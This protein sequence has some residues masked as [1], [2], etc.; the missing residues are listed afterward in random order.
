MEFRILGNLE[1]VSNGEVIDLGGNRIRAFAAGILIHACEP[2]TYDKLSSYIWDEP[3]TS[4]SANLRTYA[5]ALRRKLAIAEAG[6]DRWLKTTSGTYQLLFDPGIMDAAV[7]DSLVAESERHFTCGDIARCVAKLDR[8]LQLW[9]GRPMQNVRGSWLLS[10]EIAC[11]EERYLV[12]AERRADLF[13]A[14]RHYADSI[15]Y[16]RSLVSEFPL[17]EGLWARLMRALA[18]SNR[19]ADALAAYR[20][21]REL[22]ADSTGMEPGTILK[23]IHVAIL[24]D[25]PV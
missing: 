25:E 17:N 12:A 20:Y 14:S 21:A 16:L 13:F 7:F 18:N 22:I 1:L 2:V 15:R 19:R 8:A 4:A 3:P 23:N 5:T 24:K 9:R 10:A 6:A 11:L